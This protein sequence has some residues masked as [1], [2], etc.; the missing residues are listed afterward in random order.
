MD[1]GLSE[2]QKCRNKRPYATEKE[3]MEGAKRQSAKAGIRIYEYRC[4]VC[5]SWHLTKQRP[6]QGT[7][8]EHRLL[9]AGWVKRSVDQQVLWLDPISGKLWQKKHA[10]N[11]LRSREGDVGNVTDAYVE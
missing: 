11:V 1:G 9:A 4:A 6:S 7:K 2:K 10:M 5:N 8:D 3:A